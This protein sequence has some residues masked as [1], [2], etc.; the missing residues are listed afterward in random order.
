[1][2]KY[3]YV[4]ISVHINTSPYKYI[5][6]YIYVYIYKYICI[7]THMDDDLYL[8]RDYNKCVTKFNTQKCIPA[9]GMSKRINIQ[10]IKDTDMNVY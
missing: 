7:Y 10:I 5:C 3:F 6:I 8:K 9:K 2:Y 4:S 1:M